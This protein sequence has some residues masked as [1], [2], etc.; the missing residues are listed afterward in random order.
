MLYAIIG[1]EAEGG[2]ALRPAH[3]EA[4]LAHVKPLLDQGRLIIAGPRPNIDAAEPGSAGYAGSLIIAEFDD[5]E[6]ARAWA[7]AD[8]YLAG[9]VFES[10]EVHPFLQV[11]P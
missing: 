6:A 1:R 7:D 2:S 4:H 3:R 5:L 11:L 9:G 10:A 8:P